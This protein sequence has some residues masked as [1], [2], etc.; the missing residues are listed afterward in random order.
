M[1]R[2]SIDKNV[3]EELSNLLRLASRNEKHI[4]YH[5]LPERLEKFVG[6]EFAETRHVFYELERLAYFKSKLEFKNKNILDIGCNIGYFLFSFLDIGANH[7]TGY[8]G[9]SSCAVFIKR[10]IELLE[11]SGRFSL[12][13]QYFDFTEQI[14]M[15]DV[16]LL[17]NV[18]HHLGDDYGDAKLSLPE[19]KV[20]ILE[21]LNSLSGHTR[22]LVFQLGFNWKGNIKQCLFE[23]GTKAEMIEFV[24][25]GTKSNWRPVGIGVPQR[26]DG[27]VIYQELNEDNVKRDDA[28]GEFLNR[29]LFILESLDHA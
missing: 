15:Y 25:S 17:L 4:G 27:K 1:M 13:N 12:Y 14:S 22:Y 28:L 7:V 29:P 6:A 9:K 8:E 10:A 16:T 3:V 18:L 2:N 20:K 23:N 5:I 21:Q 11:E 26:I 24:L 19:A